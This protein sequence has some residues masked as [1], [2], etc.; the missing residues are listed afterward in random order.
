ME[1]WVPLTVSTEIMRVS[2]SSH[3]ANQIH[4]IS[5]PVRAPSQNQRFGQFAGLEHSGVNTASGKK[6]IS[7]DRRERVWRPVSLGS[8]TFYREKNFTSKKHESQLP[9]VSG[10]TSWHFYAVF[11]QAATFLSDFMSPQ[12]SRCDVYTAATWVK[13]VAVLACLVPWANTP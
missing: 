5:Q 2:S 3:A 10:G 12:F 9:N 8:L 13:P 7:N 1:N 6:D 11:T 4:V